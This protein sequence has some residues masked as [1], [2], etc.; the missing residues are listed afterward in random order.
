M[1]LVAYQITQLKFY[2]VGSLGQFTKFIVHRTAAHLTLDN[3]EQV[4]KYIVAGFAH[5]AA[6]S[7]DFG[8]LTGDFVNVTETRESLDRN[9]SLSL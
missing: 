1:N 4:A 8:A 2:R 5:L 9:F 6:S 7:R 3:E